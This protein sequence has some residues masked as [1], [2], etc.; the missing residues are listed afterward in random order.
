MKKLL[1]V[2]VLAGCFAGLRAETVITVTNTT[3]YLKLDF[4]SADYRIA[5][6][7]M[8]QTEYPEDIMTKNGLNGPEHGK[9]GG[10]NTTEMSV[11]AIV[12][13]I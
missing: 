7:T 10:K 8:H 13:D 1:L 3:E 11:V 9:I 2:A 12:A 5:A 6:E 4:K